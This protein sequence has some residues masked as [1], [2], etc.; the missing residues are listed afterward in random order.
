MDRHGGKSEVEWP[1]FMYRGGW[2]IGKTTVLNSHVPWARLEIACW[3]ISGSK[4]NQL[5]I[6]KSA[7]WKGQGGFQYRPNGFRQMEFGAFCFFFFST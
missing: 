5:Y 6:L 3:K 4:S 2:W 1:V 7:S